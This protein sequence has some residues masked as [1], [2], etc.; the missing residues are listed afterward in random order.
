MLS[1]KSSDAAAAASIPAG[2]DFEPFQHGD[3]I[4]A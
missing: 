4:V 3:D 1:K 2:A